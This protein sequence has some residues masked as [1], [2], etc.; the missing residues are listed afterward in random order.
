ML[1]G[2]IAVIRLPEV[3][4]RINAATKSAT[5][6]VSSTMVATFLFFVYEKHQI[7]GKILLAILF[8]FLTAPIVGFII[9]RTAY[10]IGIPL[11]ERLVPDDLKA[12]LE[13]KE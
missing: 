9:S 6:G 5:F 7:S 10:H 11:S 4:S 13:K 12:D 1:M 2:S 8:V 3:Y